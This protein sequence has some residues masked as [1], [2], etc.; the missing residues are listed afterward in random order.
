L[1]FLGSKTGVKFLSLGRN[2]RSASI[3]PA[4]HSISSPRTVL[5]MTETVYNDGH[6]AGAAREK[7]KMELEIT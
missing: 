7:R 2:H 5:G 1:I 6:A 4:T 3:P